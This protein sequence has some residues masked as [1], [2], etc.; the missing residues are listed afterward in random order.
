MRTGPAQENLTA[1]IA[2][3]CRSGKPPE[4]LRDAVLPRL[5]RAVPFDAAFWATTDPGTLL[6]TQAHQHALPYETVPAFLSNEFGGEDANRF[7]DL[8]VDA[9]GVRT[10]VGATGG[11][12]ERSA[13]HN[14]ILAPLGFGDEMRAVLRVDGIVWGVLCLHRAVGRP[15][16][17]EEA[18]Y[19]QRIAPLLAD[20]IRHGL[21]IAS[22]EMA[23]T[24]E[25][26]G[27]VL[28]SAE[29]DLVSMTAAGAQWLAELGHADVA[30]DGLPP[31]VLAVAAR[32]GS[33]D[34]AVPRLRMRT[35]AGRWAVLHAARLPG[36]AGDAVAIIIEEP[37]TAELAPILMIAYGLT[38][39]EREIACLACRARSTKQISAELHI[40]ANTVQQHLTSIFD[41]TGVRSRRELVST[42]MQDQY[43]PRV[44]TQQRAARSG[45]FDR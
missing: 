39:R 27:L 33:A 31:I 3:A 4:E 26:P 10:L 37:S 35:R 11:E 45:T 42:L 36:V 38:P 22:V 2:E 34:G 28:L 30:R 5:N 44:A 19:V 21:L 25:T 15:F 32:L 9:T 18:R 17:S 7:T 14:E 13:R 23:P 20:G 16:A 41:K 29:G 43:M 1:A 12:L 24:V 40:T 6:F 8:A